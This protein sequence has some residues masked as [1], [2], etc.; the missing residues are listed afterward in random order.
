[1]SAASAAKGHK[2]NRANSKCCNRF[3]H[4][5]RGYNSLSQAGTYCMLLASLSIWLKLS[6]HCIEE[7][8]T[9]VSSTAM[10]DMLDIVTSSLPSAGPLVAWPRK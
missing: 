4:C 2:F 8:M 1:M 5:S 10:S 9:T 6:E 7:E 3:S